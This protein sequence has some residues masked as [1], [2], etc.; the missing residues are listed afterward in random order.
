MSMKMKKTEYASPKHILAIPDHYVALAV[1]HEKATVDEPGIAT[2]VDGRYIIKAGTVY[3]STQI[4]GIVLNDYDVTDGDEAMA[5][6][7]HGFVKE[8]ALPAVVDTAVK[9]KMPL[10]HFVAENV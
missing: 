3:E 4:N 10:I 1:T 2:L 7:I 9:A 6:L 8:A 5:V